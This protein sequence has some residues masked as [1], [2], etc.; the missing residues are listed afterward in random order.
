[1]FSLKPSLIVLTL[2]SIL[3]IGLAVAYVPTIPQPAY[4]LPNWEDFYDGGPW[5]LD[6]GGGPEDVH[7]TQY[8]YRVYCYLCG[9]FI[10]E[11][12]GHLDFNGKLFC[13]EET[14]DISHRH[15][16]CF[17]CEAINSLS[18]LVPD[19]CDEQEPEPEPEPG[20]APERE[21]PPRRPEDDHR[22]ASGDNIDDDDG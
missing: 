1:M 4:D 9:E 7:Y 12:I 22:Y 18:N 13:D 15:N 14:I 20:P 16:I 17:I 6:C 8:Y 21:P 3:Y 2:A 19:N 11:R 10:E 5:C